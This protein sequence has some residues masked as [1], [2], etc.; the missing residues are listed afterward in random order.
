M[1]D[2]GP[3]D[4]TIFCSM[5]IPPLTLLLEVLV[6]AKII[7][8]CT[9][10]KSNEENVANSPDTDHSAQAALLITEQ[11]QPQADPQVEL[12]SADT[13]QDVPQATIAQQFTFCCL[14]NASPPIRANRLA[15]AIIIYSLIT[16]AF[17]L[18]IRET[19]NDSATNWVFT[20]LVNIVPFS[21]ASFAFL[22]AFVD[23][24]LVRWSTGLN[25]GTGD[26]WMWMP[27]MPFFIVFGSGYTILECLKIPI[28]AVMGDWELST[29]TM[30]HNE[31]EGTIEDVELQ[32][33]V[34]DFDGMADEDDGLP[35]YDEVTVS[36]GGVEG[37]GGRDGVV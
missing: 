7:C 5:V 17:A 14:P 6:N 34:D 32:G 26:G 36:E 30:S 19:Q 27:C 33:L 37:K 8:D 22:R 4:T 16:T 1:M 20:V 21:C 18:R 13:I 11:P 25:Y 2:F 3:S 28:A 9:H 35:A 29:W 15:V 31:G 12:I 23:A 10:S 24:V